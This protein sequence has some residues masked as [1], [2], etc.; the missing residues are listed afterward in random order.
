M[1]VVS[2]SCQQCDDVIKSFLGGSI[3][4]EIDFEEMI[5]MFSVRKANAKVKKEEQRKE[6]DTETPKMS[7]K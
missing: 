1:R 5:K 7:R 6:R 2:T 4:G 3:S